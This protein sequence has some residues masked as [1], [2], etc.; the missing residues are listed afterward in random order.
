MIPLLTGVA[1]TS[2]SA[3]EKKLFRRIQPAGYVLFARN[4]E[5]AAQTRALTDELHEL[6]E[7]PPILSIDQEGGRVVRTRALG[8]ESPSAWTL[9]QARDYDAIARHGYWTASLLKQLGFNMNLAP[10]LDIAQDGQRAN[11][12][13]DR[14]WSTDVNE[15]VSCAGVYVQALLRR[16]VAS[17]GKHFPGLGRARVDAHFELPV[18]EA[19]L[20]DLLEKDIIPFTA[21]G[22][23][24]LSAVM[25]AHVFFPRLDPDHPSSLS[26]RILTDLLRNQ[27]GYRGLLMTDDLDMGAIVSRYSLPEASRLAILAGNDLAMICHSQDALEEAAHA[28]SSLP[29]DILRDRRERLQNFLWKHASRTEAFEP[30]VWEMVCRETDRLREQ[31]AEAGGEAALSSPVQ[32]Y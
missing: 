29:G 18:V 24:L 27:L 20:E 7:C 14:C 19:S 10:V 12:L 11:A 6:S 5:T 2:L 16:G 26:R 22:D 17:C 23:E 31:F 21:L 4:V 25:C 3:A 9:G 15:V 32:E 13:P 1:G 28:L 8:V 30:A